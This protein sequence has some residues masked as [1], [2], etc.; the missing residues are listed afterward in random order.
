MICAIRNVEKSL[1]DGR[2]KRTVS[3]EK[4][5]IAARKSIVARCPI[6]KG[7]VFTEEN[8]TVKRPGNGI[9]PMKWTELLNTKAVRDYD[10]DELI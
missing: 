9:S 5:C 10:T 8:L 1:G 6:K 2:K 7:D 4:N 3:E